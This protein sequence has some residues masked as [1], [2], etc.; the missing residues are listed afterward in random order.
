MITIDMTRL[1]LM[2]LAATIVGALCGSNIQLSMFSFWL[3]KRQQKMDAEGAFAISKLR[4]LCNH[5]VLTIDE[6]KQM[7]GQPVW[8]VGVSDA[9]DDTQGAW[10]IIDYV[11]EDGPA[12]SKIP[13]K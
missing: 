12:P 6:L 13:P 4:E 7:V 11:D 10:D 2:V 8:T 1:S 5:R 3:K 9:L